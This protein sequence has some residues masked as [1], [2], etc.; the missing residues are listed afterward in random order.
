MDLKRVELQIFE[1]GVIRLLYIANYSEGRGR[2]TIQQWQTNYIQLI[3]PVLE[4]KKFYNNVDFNLLFFFFFQKPECATIHCSIQRVIHKNIFHMTRRLHICHKIQCFRF[5]VV[6]HHWS[7]RFEQSYIYF[8]TVEGE[9]IISHTQYLSLSQTVCYIW[10]L[11]TTL[12]FVLHCCHF[13]FLPLS[14]TN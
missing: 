2:V 6:Q 1:A 14:I 8:E 7:T 11:L 9:R 10:H 3:R 4:W 13:P 12:T 5:T